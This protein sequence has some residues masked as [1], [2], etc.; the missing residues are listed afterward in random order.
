MPW[1]QS[2]VIPFIWKVLHRIPLGSLPP[3]S[4]A[5]QGSTTSWTLLLDF[6]IVLNNC[7]AAQR[8]PE[9]EQGCKNFP[10]SQFGFPILHHAFGIDH[11]RCA[12][13]R[14]H[15]NT[16]SL[17][18]D[19]RS[20]NTC[21]NNT[22]ANSS[23]FMLVAF[24]NFLVWWNH[25]L[26]QEPQDRETPM[27]DRHIKANQRQTMLHRDLLSVWDPSLWPFQDDHSC[28]D[29]CWA[30]EGLPLFPPFSGH[31]VRYRHHNTLLGAEHHR[32]LM[33]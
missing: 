18:C 2:L 19:T 30:R 6:W 27:T 16:S 28:A 13:L 5:C 7:T 11:Y 8:T 33:K 24:G 23:V 15:W 14:R 4:L 22:D 12:W 10:F 29:E 26:L 3:H 32:W 21:L 20:G 9:L 17:A 25:R 31:H 1:R